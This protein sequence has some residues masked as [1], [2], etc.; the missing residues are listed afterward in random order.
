[1]NHLVPPSA[2]R[3]CLRVLG[4]LSLAVLVVMLLLGALLA[5]PALRRRGLQHRR[6]S[7]R[8]VDQRVSGGSRSRP[9][10]GLRPALR[11]RR[12]AQL[13]H[14]A[15]T[16]SSAT[17]RW[18]PTGS[19]PGRAPWDR[20]AACGYDF[21]TWMGE[22]IAAGYA[23]AAKVFA[24]W[25]NSPDHNENMVNP[26][27]KVIG[28][29][30]VYVSGSTYRYYWTTDFGGYVDSTAH[31]VG[32][33]AATTTTAAPTTT[34]TTATTT[35]ADHHDHDGLRAADDHDHDDLR[36]P[37]TTHDH[38]G[39]ADHHDHH[40]ADHPTTVAVCDLLRR[41][42]RHA[43]RR[44]DT[45]CWPARASSRGYGDGT[46]RPLRHGDAA[47]VRQDDR[48]GPRLHGIAGVGL[49]VQGCATRAR[50]HRILS[51]RPATSRPVRPRA[52]R[53]AR[54]PT[55]SVP[56]TDHPGATDHHGRPC[57]RPRRAAVVRTSPRSPTSAP[58]HYPWARRAAYAG[59]LDGFVGMGPDFD[60]WASATRGEVCLLLADLLGQ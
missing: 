34:T 57:R 52:S 28:V 12:P 56:T 53:S 5:S 1:M 24:A 32:S 17:T 29:S 40:E 22:N 30:L 45:G 13:R 7:V 19:P 50:A 6:D 10:A 31:S 44:S 26:N 2:S 21:N 18:L 37:P 39:A 35:T 54:P 46:I 15:S 38:H 33:A 55:P 25:K 60:F 41:E 42:Q 23:T 16:A 20:M 14:G 58:Q 59:L 47:A 8:A 43:V 27:F 49:L 36:P 48:A 11:L 4:L 51:I 3:A 9:S